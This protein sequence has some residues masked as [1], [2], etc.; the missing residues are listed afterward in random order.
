[1]YFNKLKLISK[2]VWNDIELNVIANLNKVGA[3]K[4]I[5]NQNGLNLKIISINKS[6]QKSPNI[7]R[8]IIDSNFGLPILDVP[9]AFL[10]PPSSDSFETFEK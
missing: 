4:E 8:Y 7:I 1:M 6:Q 5:A 3:V 2:Y 10:Q 9:H